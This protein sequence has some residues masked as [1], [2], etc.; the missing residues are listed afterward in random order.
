MTGDVVWGEA[1]TGAFH[2]GEAVK[3]AAIEQVPS[4]VKGNRPGDGAFA[5]PAWAVDG[6]NGDCWHTLLI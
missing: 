3:G 4:G 2:R 6:G 5:G 1:A